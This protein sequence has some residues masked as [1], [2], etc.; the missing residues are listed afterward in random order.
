MKTTELYELTSTQ[1]KRDPFCTVWPGSG[2]GASL[3]YA[4]ATVPSV[5][6]GHVGRPTCHAYH[7]LGQ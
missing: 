7:I 5:G 6:S 1:L 2:A 4:A 3:L